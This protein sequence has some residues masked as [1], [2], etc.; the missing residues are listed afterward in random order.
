LKNIVER[1]LIESGGGAITQEHLRFVSF[2]SASPA[3]AVPA[4]PSSAPADS[5]ASA[6]AAA[7]ASVSEA[8]LD[9]ILQYVRQRGSIN[10]TECRQL[11]AVGLQH[12]CYLLRKAAAAG[13]LQ[14]K[15]SGRWTRYHLPLEP[16][17]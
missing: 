4:R 7:E 12:A 11:L 10:N 2:H 8:Q 3:A 9:E 16:G 14:R 13:L 15:G 17:R 5:A 6:P 1:A